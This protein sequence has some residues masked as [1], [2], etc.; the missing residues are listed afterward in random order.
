MDQY[1]ID[2][3]IKDLKNDGLLDIIISINRVYG[4]DV[5]IISCE[6]LNPN[7]KGNCKRLV[8]DYMSRRAHIP[9]ECIENLYFSQI[10]KQSKNIFDIKKD[11]LRRKYNENEATIIYDKI[12][13]RAGNLPLCYYIK[14]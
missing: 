1:S 9:I 8:T 5:A 3:F 14:S 13:K 7:R 12:I 6:V 11:I 4:Q 2:S 10:I